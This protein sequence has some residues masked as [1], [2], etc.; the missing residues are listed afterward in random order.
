VQNNQAITLHSTQ[1]R[2]PVEIGEQILAQVR[3]RQT[4]FLVTVAELSD[5]RVTVT[6][7]ERREPAAIGQS[8]VLY[9]GE[10]CLGGGIIK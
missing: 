7:T 6:P 3:Y 9:R 2:Q 10:N 4:P 1:L 8:C 5:G